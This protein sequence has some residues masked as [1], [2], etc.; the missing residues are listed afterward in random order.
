MIPEKKIENRNRVEA[1]FSFIEYLHSNIGTYKK[2]EGTV[3]KIHHLIN[4]GK[5][6]RPKNNYRD[7]QKYDEIQSLRN[8]KFKVVRENI[9]LPIKNKAAELNICDVNKTETLWNWNISEI[10]E[11]KDNFKEEDIPE[12]LK[13][14]KKYLEY[15]TAT[16]GED[17][18]ELQFFFGDLDKVL[19]H[20]FDYFK[21]T[22]SNEFEHFEK[23][24]IKVAN[25]EEAIHLLKKGHTSFT[26]PN[27]FLSTPLKDKPN[28]SGD[29]FHKHN[30]KDNDKLIGLITHE[31]NVE[32]VEG[33]KKRC[34]NIRGKNLKLLFLAMRD[35]QLLPPGRIAKT[36]HNRCK[37]EFNWD[38]ASYNAMNGY[39]FND[40]TDGDD[41]KKY[42]VL[43]ESIIK[44]N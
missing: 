14:K 40:R 38:I 42:K 22:E 18:F 32:I 35:M 5:S 2:L 1:L 33:I 41:F 12:I 7:K 4:D 17:F 39:C 16:N 10:N 23:K 21:D 20:F 6:L 25:I 11:L 24:T 19:K 9:T 31:K 34:K 30:D 28:R 43:L 37:L 8:E 13:Y 26:I 15:R 3:K 36:F 29:L 27:S 44:A